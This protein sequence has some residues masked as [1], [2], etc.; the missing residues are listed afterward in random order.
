[1]KRLRVALVVPA[2]K[3]AATRCVHRDVVLAWLVLSILPWVVSCAPR[4]V[5]TAGPEAHGAGAVRLDPRAAAVARAAGRLVGAGRLVVDGERFRYDCSGL[6]DA[7]HRA[8]GI[9]LGMRNT[10]ALWELA[11]REGLAWRRP[12]ARPGDVVFFDD[13]YDRNG[14]GRLDDSLTHAAVVE[15]VA[16]D[17]TLTLVHLGSR[18]VVRIAMNALRPHDH[19]D[20]TGRV[21][22]DFLRVRRPGDPPGTAYLAAELWRGSA[23]LWRLG[24]EP[25]ARA[26]TP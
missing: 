9:D 6:V 13:T 12:S 22:N 2:V 23:S 3:L 18:G 24:E 26:E 7:A 11:E 14:N 4:A 5:R 8:A 1:M 16:P 10:R 15:R 17:G 20:A 25:V 21:I 19:V